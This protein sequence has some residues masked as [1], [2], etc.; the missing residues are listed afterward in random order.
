MVE[1]QARV[2]K[3]ASGPEGAR[4][5]QLTEVSKFLKEVLEREDKKSKNRLSVSISPSKSSSSPISTPVK[6]NVS[7]MYLTWDEEA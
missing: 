5:N 2:N 1:N 3:E 7:F 4:V 6:Q